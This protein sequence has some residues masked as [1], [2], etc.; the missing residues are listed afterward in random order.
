[1]PLHRLPEGPLLR[2]TL[3]LPDRQR[4]SHSPCVLLTSRSSPQWHLPPFALL[5]RF[6]GYGAVQLFSGCANRVVVGD[7]SDVLGGPVFCWQH[8]ES[9]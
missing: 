2:V 1:M 8:S 5:R 4:V 6:R 3:Q 7:D 9:V